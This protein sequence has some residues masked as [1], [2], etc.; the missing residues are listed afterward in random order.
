M[1]KR[2]L[3]KNSIFVYLIGT[4]SILLTIGVLINIL[5]YTGEKP[6]EPVVKSGDFPFKLV[7]EVEGERYTIEDTLL[8]RY[9]GIGYDAESLEYFN[10][11][12]RI[13]KSELDILLPNPSYADN[14]FYIKL[15]SG[16][17][18]GIG[19]ID[20]C[21]D[22]GSSDYYMG[23]EEDESSFQT[24]PGDIYIYPSFQVLSENELSEKHGIK[25]IEKYVSSPINTEN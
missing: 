14:K 9:E 24:Q 21:F 23:I 3:F 16:H 19:S 13:Y 10:Q 5:F 6:K 18:D 1:R 22:L 17:N 11:W 4:A 8:I 15:Y 12:N 7:Y 2:A 20:I 25:I